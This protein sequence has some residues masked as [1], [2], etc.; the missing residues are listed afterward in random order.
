V[1][2]QGDRRAAGVAKMNEVYGWEMPANVPGDFFAMT[3]EHLF[4]E[5]WT[6]PGFDIRERRLLLIGLLVGLGK[7]DV[8]DI[9]LASALK[10]GELDVRQLR[11][12]VI[13]FAHYA[14]WPA[15]ATLNTR[16]EKLI[17]AQK[18]KD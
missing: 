2:E 9:Q 14:G 7:E 12:L 5:V 17:A 10:R 18:P 15:A 13:F 8:L 3:V 4:A 11:E 16:V 6:R 1:S